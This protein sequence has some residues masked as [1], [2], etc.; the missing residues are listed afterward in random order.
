VSEPLAHAVAQQFIQADAA[1]RRSL[2]QALSVATTP[3]AFPDRHTAQDYIRIYQQLLARS[4]TQAA[5]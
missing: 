4:S 5:A 2:I 1:S 3:F